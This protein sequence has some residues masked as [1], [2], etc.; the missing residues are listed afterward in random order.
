VAL[1]EGG[2][3][4]GVKGAFL[5][6]VRGGLLIDRIE[7]GLELSPF[8]YLPYTASGA[9]PNFQVNATF[10]YHIRMSDMLSWPVRVGAGLVAGNT[11]MTTS[12]F[13]QARAD[14][15]GLSVNYGH[16][17]FDMHFPSFRFVTEFDRAAFLDWLV[18]GG[19]SYA[20]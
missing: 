6:G 10:G 3:P 14:L 19:A 2:A 15:L 16:L 12:P 17:L 11:L 20:F 13:F 8:T 7:L 18:G 4:L 1:L 5:A 9:D